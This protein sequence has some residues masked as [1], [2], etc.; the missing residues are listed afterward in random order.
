M[1]GVK[2]SWVDMQKIRQALASGERGDQARLEKMRCVDQTTI[3][4]W[5]AACEVLEAIEGKHEISHVS[6]FQP[7]HATAIAQAMRRQGKDLSDDSVKDEIAE[8][9]E[10]CEAEKLTVQ[11]LKQS[12]SATGGAAT[13]E[14]KGCTVTDLTDLTDAGK[15]FGTIYADP[16]WQYGNQA[17]RASTDNHYLTMP[18]AE[19]EALPIAGM[20]AEN[21]HLH[22]WTTNGFIQEA[23][24]IIAAW[25]FTYKSMFIWCKPKMGI[26]NY[27]RVSHE[28]L[29]LGVRGSCPFA[30]HSLLSW[31]ELERG[32]HSAKPEKVREFIEKASPSPR[33][34]LFGRDARNGWAVWGNQ[35]SRDL[36]HQEVEEFSA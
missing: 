32:K 13:P 15:K 33:L 19:I 35:V 25:G 6:S 10:R 5:K 31:A 21:S 22:L 12:L 16:P 7:S 27:W 26:G 23:F 14:D 30:D 36:F 17:T 29:L 24:G 28:I 8:W 2:C 9:V 11:Q 34:E 18:I 3:S 1:K 20:A 4:T